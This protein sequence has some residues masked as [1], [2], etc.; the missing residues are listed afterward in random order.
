MTGLSVVKECVEVAIRQ[1]ARGGMTGTINVKLKVTL[2]P[3]RVRGTV[4][5]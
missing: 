3:D 5:A 1:T 4:A 2:S